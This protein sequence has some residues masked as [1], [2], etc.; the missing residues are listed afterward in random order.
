MKMEL[1]LEA[2]MESLSNE[3]WTVGTDGGNGWVYYY[4]GKELHAGTGT[5]LDDFLPRECLYVYERSERKHWSEADRKAHPYMELE[6]G[7][8]FIVEGRENGRI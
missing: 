4:D 5:P 2:A 3:P 6:A 8:A 1:T 7:L